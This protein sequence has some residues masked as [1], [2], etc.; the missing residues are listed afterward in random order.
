MNILHLAY[1][2]LS[3]I[4]Y[5]VSNFPDGQQFISIDDAT[6]DFR[7]EIVI[8][9]RFNSWKDLELIICATQVLRNITSN[10]IH[11]Y[12]PYIL[13]ARS[14]RIFEKNGLHYVKQVSAPVINSMNYASVWV[15]DPHSDVLEACINNL[16]HI[17][18]S[19]FYRTAYGCD[20]LVA[21]DAGAYK[22]TLNASKFIQHDTI[23]TCNKVRD[24]SGNI[25]KTEAPIQPSDK[26]NKYIIID[27]ICDGGRT[28]IEIAKIIKSQQP[29]SHITLCVTH[30]IFSKGIPL[31]GIDNI[32][33]TNSYQDIPNAYFYSLF[34]NNTILNCF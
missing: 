32:I 26:R 34:T 17:D 23:I 22:R 11:L 12:V 10:K 15:A 18:L 27:D 21:P 25:I 29:N 31:E 14:D 4:Q 30:G 16:Q 19:S 8:V 2:E 24:K 6:I 20:I 13:G 28:F 33:S 7:N 9:S 5:K 3:H 1:P